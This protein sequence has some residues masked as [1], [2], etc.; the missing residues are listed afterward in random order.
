MTLKTVRILRSCDSVYYIHGDWRKVRRSLEN[1]CGGIKFFDSPAFQR[2]SDAGRTALAGEKICKELK[3]GNRVVYLTY[4]NPALLSD[5]L[6][7]LEY[8]KKKGYKGDIVPA[9][10]SVDG[11]LALMADERELFSN[12]FHVCHA[13]VFAGRPEVFSA[14]AACIA[15]GADNLVSGGGFS[16]FC[17]IIE[18]RY[19]GRRFIYLVRCG[20]GSDKDI[21]IRLKGGELRGAKKKITHMMSIILPGTASAGRRK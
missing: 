19:P 13:E 2:M 3:K 17:D 1:I 4:G 21:V 15:L 9:P 8:C 18:A 14:H 5:G 10:S 7:M 20:D 11:I 12:G 16:R 6:N